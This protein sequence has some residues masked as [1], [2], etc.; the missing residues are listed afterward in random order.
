MAS[1][2]M[3]KRTRSRKQPAAVMVAWPERIALAALLVLLSGVLVWQGAQWYRLFLEPKQTRAPAPAAPQ[4][5]STGAA[6]RIVAAHLFGAAA[7]PEP[8]ATEVSTLAIK[9]KGVFADGDG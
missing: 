5:S 7:A 4:V 2:V 3:K 1:R 9:L 8:A 6:D